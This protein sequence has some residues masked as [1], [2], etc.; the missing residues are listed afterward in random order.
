M[1][2]PSM[3]TTESRPPHKLSACRDFSL[4]QFLLPLQTTPTRSYFL[5]VDRHRIVLLVLLNTKVYI[6]MAA[7]SSENTV[8]NFGTSTSHFLQ[9][10]QNTW[11]CPNLGSFVADLLMFLHKADTSSFQ[12]T[13]RDSR[14]WWRS[15]FTVYSL[16]IFQIWTL[17]LTKDALNHSPREKF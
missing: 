12:K 1:R 5:L 14:L 11:D 3:Q 13:T 16:K 2:Q 8:A 15:W 10:L 7:A 4:L 17:F 9:A 6:Q